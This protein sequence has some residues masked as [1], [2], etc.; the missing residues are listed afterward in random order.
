MLG[1]SKDSMWCQ[2]RAGAVSPSRCSEF[3]VTGR[4]SR[5]ALP[6][7]AI[8]LAAWS[9]TAGSVAC[10]WLGSYSPTK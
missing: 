1:M 8:G 6:L 3:R 2:T 10:A 9:S 5:S 4:F 7:S